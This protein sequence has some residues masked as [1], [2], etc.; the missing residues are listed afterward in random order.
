[1]I[2]AYQQGDTT[3]GIL[4]PL[5]R[6]LAILKSRKTGFYRRSI[7]L[8]S[9][10]TGLLEHQ[11]R[12]EEPSSG[13]QETEN[14]MPQ[15]TQDAQERDDGTKQ[16]IEDVQEREVAEIGIRTFLRSGKLESENTCTRHERM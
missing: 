6:R 1:M 16:Q 11:N 7:R 13:V 10:T 2:A 14:F 4:M 3:C 15:Q 8:K 12:R 9:R 5:D